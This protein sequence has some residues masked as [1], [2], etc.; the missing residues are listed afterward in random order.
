MTDNR[1]EVSALGAREKF[2]SWIAERGGVQVWENQN[3]SDPDAGSMYTP[4]MTEQGEPMPAPHWSVRAGEIVTEIERFR[5]AAEVVEVDRLHVA[6][7]RSGNGLMVK[8]TD[9]STRRIRGR[10]MKAE[11]KYGDRVIYRFDYDT[12]DCVI[13]VIVFEGEDKATVLQEVPA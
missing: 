10:C 13:F 9:G 6:I 1:I 5:F 4:L 2:E 12:Q 11:M 7:R 8:C 3:M